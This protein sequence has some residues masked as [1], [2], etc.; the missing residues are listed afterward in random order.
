MNKLN[1][2][3]KEKTLEEEVVGQLVR[4][5]DNIPSQDSYHPVLCDTHNASTL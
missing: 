5:P 3:L 1:N 2:H 4:N